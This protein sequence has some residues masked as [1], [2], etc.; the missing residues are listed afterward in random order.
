VF[1]VNATLQQPGLYA[2]A[3]YK[4]VGKQ[5]LAALFKDYS[6]YVFPP[7]SFSGLTSRQAKPGEIIVVY[8]VGF[9]PVPGNPPGQIAQAAN[10]LTLPVAPKFFFGGTPAQVQY[11]GLVAGTVGLYQFNLFVPSIPDSDAVPLTFSVNLNGTD[12]AG[13]QTLYTAVHK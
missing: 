7:N 13:A 11:A 1:N 12:V 2:P 9:G 10:G 5:Y 4:I 8:G 6:T 3:V